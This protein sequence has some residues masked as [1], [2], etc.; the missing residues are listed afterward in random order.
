VRTSPLNCNASHC[1]A[2]L[3]PGEAATVNSSRPALGNPTALGV[4]SLLLTLQPLAINWLGW[5][6]N[7][8][9]GVSR[10][11]SLAEA[12]LTPLGDHSR[13]VAIF[14]L[15]DRPPPWCALLYCLPHL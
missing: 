15:G 7:A 2:D 1:P 10:R 14:H 9:A 8:A 12:R 5:G 6:P 3:T 13:S 4:A 11:L